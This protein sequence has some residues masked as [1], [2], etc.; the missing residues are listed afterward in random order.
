MGDG[1][2]W[3]VLAAPAGL[4]AN[5]G[6]HILIARLTGGRRVSLG[7]ILGMAVGAVAAI[8]LSAFALSSMK[9]PATEGVVFLTYN[10]VIYLAL[11]YGYWNFINLNIT[12]LRIRLIQELLLSEHGLA[13]AEILKQYNADEMIDRRLARLTRQKHLVERD[14][15]FYYRRSVLLLIAGI[16]DM[17]KWLILA[18]NRLLLEAERR[19]A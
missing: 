16:L 1:Y 15:R 9:K 7:I 8:A 3:L 19:R 17:L 6:A 4:T 14:G 5:V 2:P 13:R 18:R 11:A 12:S 10:L